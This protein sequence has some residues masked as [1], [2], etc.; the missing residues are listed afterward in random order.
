MHVT[1]SEAKQSSLD[2]QGASRL[3]ITIAISRAGSAEVAADG[4][5]F[6]LPLGAQRFRRKSLQLAE[7]TCNALAC[8]LDRRTRIAMRAIRP[9]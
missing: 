9:K 4:E 2:R 6:V 5:I 1:A 7:R 3:A 8:G